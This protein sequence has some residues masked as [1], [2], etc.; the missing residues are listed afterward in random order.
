M[1][2]KDIIIECVKCGREEHP[3]HYINAKDMVRRCMC[4]GCNLW[5]ERLALR[6]NSNFV[7]ANGSMYTIGDENAKGYFRGFGGHPVTINFNDGRVVKSTNLWHGGSIPPEF[8]NEYPNNA[9]L[10]WD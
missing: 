8:K 5:T 3:Y 2:T 1:R 7:V 6:N 4:F 9:T 10:V